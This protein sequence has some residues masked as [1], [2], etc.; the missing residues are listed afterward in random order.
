M[1]KDGANSHLSSYV[2]A[3]KGL[4]ILGFLAM[5]AVTACSLGGPL[6][7][8]AIIDRS[9][10]ARDV[11][12]MLRWAGAYLALVVASGVITYVEMI[13]VARLGLDIVTGIKKDMFAHLLRLP[14]SYFD[15]HPVGELMA[16]T[17]SDCE[18]VRDL[19]SR[20]GLSLAVSVLLLL[21][22][23][24]V[25]FSLEPD[26]TLWIAIGLPV[27]IGAVIALY[28]RL[29][30]LYDKSRKLW[31]GI[32]AS[33]TE[34]IQ[35]VEILKAFGRVPWAREALDKTAR[36]KRAVDIRAGFLEIGAMSALGFAIGPLFMASVMV[37]VSPKILSGAMSLGTLMVFLD[38]GA[39]LF[40]PVMGIAENVRGIQQARVSL[41]RIAGILSLERE[42]GA[43][44]AISS[45][46]GEIEA[47]KPAVLEHSIEFRNV[48]FAYKG[49]E[50]VLK[51]VSFTVPR[52][53]TIALVGPSGSGKTTTVGLLCRF[54]RPQRGQILVD[55]SP[56]EERDLRS[57]RRAIGLVLQDSYLFPGPL[58]E[59]VRVYDDN[60]DEKRVRS[61]LAMVRADCF[62]ARLPGGLSAEIRERGSNISAGEKQLISFARAVAFG[63]SIVVLDEATASIDVKTERMIKEGMAELLAGRTAVI[64][65]HRLSSVMSA[66]Q[67]LYFKDGR[68]VARGRHEELMAAFGDYAQLVRLQFLTPQPPGTE[69]GAGA[70]APGASAGGEET[71][72]GRG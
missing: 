28:D 2:S 10:P 8:R 20:A 7:L 64:V 34:F 31:A 55:G 60:L 27:V 67:I 72:A 18:K 12:G 15:E 24:A 16:R 35:G 69:V 71:E 26:V 66:D 57:W 17:E 44:E 23:L 65:A 61:A 59:N 42:L 36:E 51:D 13:V 63:P 70:A 25:C 4:F 40:D 62:V 9:I 47:I 5:L 53:S 3:R 58:L 11:P 50:W 33:V 6:I 48:W 30:P 29:R 1:G 19:F 56:L 43:V 37:L 52:G 45:G 14:V 38:Y 21:G 68:I 41:K 22:M 49:E 39:R 32:T 46:H 54:Y